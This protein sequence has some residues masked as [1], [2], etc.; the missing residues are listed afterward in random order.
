M[1]MITI[2]GAG[3]AGLLAASILARRGEKVVVVEAQDELPNNHSAL[4]RFR[5]PLVGE[6]VGIP[7]RRVKVVKYALPWRN[8]VADALA[9]AEKNLGEYRSDRSA[10]LAPEIVD[11]WIAPPDLVARMYNVAVNSRVSFVFGT[12]YEFGPAWPV[13]STMPMPALMDALYYDGPRPEF[14]YVS[15][16]NVRAKIEGCD[17][18]VSIAVPDPAL[19]FSRVS[20]TGDELIIEIPR[21][22]ELTTF[23]KHACVESAV[24]LLGIGIDRISSVT[25]SLQTYSK[26][27]PIDDQAR[28]TFIFWASTIQRRSFSLGRFA[29]WRPGLLMDDL[30]ND[31]HVIE[32][33]MDSPHMGY[34]A[35]QMEIRR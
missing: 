4:L 6:T 31:V 33:L 9:Y 8:P 16:V 30:I 18:Y 2:V 5:T 13:I 19:P 12:K 3:L 32:R 15:G 17:A 11:R 35:Q 23:A 10:G 24:E 1:N 14:S 26:I 34:V 7:F 29:T 25:V 20:I 28:Q 27:A 21:I 22:T